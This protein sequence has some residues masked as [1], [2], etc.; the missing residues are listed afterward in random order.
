MAQLSGHGW[1]M[2]FSITINEQKNP[3]SILQLGLQPSLANL[4]LSSQS[5]LN[6]FMPSPQFGI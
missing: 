4:F 2:D 3:S 5:S 6:V 1:Q